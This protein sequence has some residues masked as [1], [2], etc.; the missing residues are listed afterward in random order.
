MGLLSRGE[1]NLS[2]RRALRNKTRDGWD[3]LA[4]VK[5]TCLG[6]G[7]SEIKPGVDGTP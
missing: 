2:R 5:A 6:E 1:G 4:V 7:H 3:S